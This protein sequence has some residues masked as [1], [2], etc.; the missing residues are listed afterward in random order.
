[1]KLHIGGKE[2]HPDWKIFNVQDYPGVDYVGNANDLGMFD[3]ESIETIYASHIL[4]HFYYG[5]GSE[6]IFTLAE[7]H[8]VLKVGGELMI[9]VPDIQTLC[10]LYSQPKLDVMKRLHIMRMMFGGQVDEYDVHKVGLD[11]D[12]L[13]IYLNEVGFKG[14][15]RV[16]EFNLFKDCSIITFLGYSISLNVVATK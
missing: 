13:A 11:F 3:D 15:R 4:E 8:R 10:W 12:I 2:V 5:L 7:W 14:Y 16:A 1:M 6:L 9:S